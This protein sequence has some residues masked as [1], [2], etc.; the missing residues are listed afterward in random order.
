MSGKQHL[1]R[2]EFWNERENL[3]RE[4]FNGVTIKR[5]KY[6]EERIRFIDR[7]LNAM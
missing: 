1:I 3:R 6:I 4:M 7:K 2:R 5:L